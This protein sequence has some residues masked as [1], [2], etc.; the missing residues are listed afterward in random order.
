MNINKKFAALLVISAA[1]LS[2]QANAAQSGIEKVV[3]N[4]VGNAVNNVSMEINQQVQKITLTASNMISISPTSDVIGTVTITDIS[5]NSS[6][7]TVKETSNEMTTKKSEA[8][9]NPDAP[10]SEKQSAN[11]A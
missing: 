5:A 2:I 8:A 10:K 9:N 3:G 1:T 4:L 6:T 7:D 11:D